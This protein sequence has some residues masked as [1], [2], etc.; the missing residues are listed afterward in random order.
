MTETMTA[1]TGQADSAIAGAEL[2]T[3]IRERFKGARAD[4]VIVFA[5]AQ[6][7]YGALL[8][9]LAVAAPASAAEVQGLAA[10]ASRL[11]FDLVVRGGGMSTG[12]SYV[13][14]TARMVG[15]RRSPL[16]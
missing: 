12:R 6:H 2:G 1:I 9:A 14:A 8:E 7:D 15:C 11:D 4:A 13:P 16:R 10:A 5:S 3:A